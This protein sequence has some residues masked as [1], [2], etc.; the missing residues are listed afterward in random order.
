MDEK[1]DRAEKKKESWLKT[2]L[3]IV[4]GLFSG[5]LVMYLT[6]LLNDAIK[7]TKPVANFRIERDGSTARIHNLSLDGQGWLDY[8]DG[9]PLQPVVPGGGELF[10]HTYLAAGDYTVKMTL[11]NLLGDESERS[12]PLRIEETSDKQGPRLQAL[13]VIPVSPTSYAPATFRVVSQALNTQLYIWDLGDGRPLEI[14]SQTTGPHERLVTFPKAGTYN[15]RLAA[16]NGVNHDEKTQTVTVQ[17][18]PAGTITAILTATDEGLRREVHFQQTHFG[19]SLPHDVTDA[20]LP[21]ERQVFCESGCVLRDAVIT[22]GG[23][24]EIRLGN[25]ATIPLD[26]ALLGWKQV[27][28]LALSAG[29][30]RR[31]LKLTGEYVRDTALL[32]AGRA[33]LPH[34]TLQ[35]TLQEERETPSGR[36]VTPMTT[37]LKLPAS[38]SS[39]SAV[40]ALPPL[41]PSWV[42]GQRKLLLEL[43]DG[44]RVAWQQSQLPCSAGLTLQQ[45]PYQVTATASKDQIKIE[46]RDS[47]VDLNSKTE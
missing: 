33:P 41:P 9:S 10:E 3:G 26:P 31:T 46:L 39:S 6:P 32:R 29:P 7:L 19:V 30:D 40:L 14:H 43:R 2:I 13:Q 42:K 23:G 17:E 16:V 38:G 5:A 4:G 27:Q 34:L 18:A 15:L 36:T 20:V 24:K 8:G 11:H 22:L 35:V 37:T 1:P 45:H 21:F 44:E 28:N 47:L 25:K 12:A